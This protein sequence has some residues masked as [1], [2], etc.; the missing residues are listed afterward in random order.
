MRILLAFAAAMVLAGP[1]VGQ[2]AI[3]ALRGHDV[4]Q[5]IDVDSARA[6]LRDA[7]KVLTLSG[8]VTVR[9]G[10]MTLKSDRMRVYYAQ[11]AG[12]DRLSILRIDAQGG[13]DFTSPSETV[14][15]NW[16]I[17]DVSERQLTLGGDV[18]LNRPG[19][20]SIAGQRVEINL[21][22]GLT[23]LDG[24]AGEG[25]AASRVT[26]RFEVPNRVQ[27]AAPATPKNP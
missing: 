19:T 13:L 17:Y 22:S 23:T 21:R 18:R 14:K 7:D 3:S 8:G 11:A 10:G 5:P 9:Q 6:E 24:R 20:A 16:A 25:A 12:S 4:N 26:G 1:A 2:Q 27:G 15:A